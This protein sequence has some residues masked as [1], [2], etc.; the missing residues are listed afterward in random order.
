MVR[1]LILISGR[2][3]RLADKMRMMIW[4]LLSLRGW[5][6]ILNLSKLFT[7][8]CSYYFIARRIYFS[9]SIW[10]TLIIIISALVDKKNIVKLPS[11]KQKH[12]HRGRGAISCLIKLQGKFFYARW[13]E[14]STH[15]SKTIR[16][17]AIVSVSWMSHTLEDHAAIPLAPPENK[18]WNIS[19]DMQR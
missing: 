2:G 9:I 7:A 19:K 10:K 8:R 16:Q 13:A 11:Y 17:G 18:S 12:H 14:A 4:A 1:G 15:D 6:W 5:Q 3:Q